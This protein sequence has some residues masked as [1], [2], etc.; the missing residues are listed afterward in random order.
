MT[1]SFD[2]AEGYR[3]NFLRIAST[4]GV[5]K[6]LVGA[7]LDM[8]A[9]KERQAGRDSNIPDYLFFRGHSRSN[10][11][12]G[13][14]L[15]E[16]KDTGLHKGRPIVRFVGWRYI[17]RVLNDPANAHLLE[18]EHVLSDLTQDEFAEKLTATATEPGLPDHVR[19][20]LAEA[21]RRAKNPDSIYVSNST[22]NFR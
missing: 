5:S 9:E 13:F 7:R 11:D 15:T 20:I 2:F 12:C 1:D 19:E 18:Q 21:A 10:G 16:E 8:S 3:M 6:H 22:A 14:A 17:E 4:L